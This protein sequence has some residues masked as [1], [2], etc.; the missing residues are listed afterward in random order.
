M[1][2]GKSQKEW[3]SFYLKLISIC[4]LI[5]ERSGFDEISYNKIGAG[6]SGTVDIWTYDERYFVGF[7][8]ED[9]Q[10]TH[11]KHPEWY[12]DSSHARKVVGSGEQFLTTC[13]SIA[14]VVTVTVSAG[15][16]SHTYQYVDSI[17]VVCSSGGGSG[18]PTQ[19]HGDGT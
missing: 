11:T 17:T 10:L 19:G 13:R 7:V 2:F 18:S 1:S 9:G 12:M 3:R 15:G 6:W 4:E 14:T 16:S 5:I 8:I